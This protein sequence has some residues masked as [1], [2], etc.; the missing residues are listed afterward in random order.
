MDATHD[1]AA[2]A[3]AYLARVEAVLAEDKL[4][5]YEPYGWQREFHNAGIDNPER[6][7]MAASRVGKSLA[8]A[9]EVAIHLTG[10]YPSWW[11][12]KR[13]DGAILVWCGSVSNEA[14]RDIV[15]KQLIGGTGEELGRGWI[16]KRC[17][18]GKPT[19]RQAGVANVVDTVKVRHVSGGLSTLVTKTYEQGWRKWQG[20]APHVVWLDEE[21]GSGVGSASADDYRI[22]EEAQTRILTSGGVVLV[23]FTPLLG[24]T[25]L[26]EHFLDD[27]IQGTYIKSATWDDA[28]H[29]PV[30]EKERLRG[31][32]PV[33]VVE[34]RTLGIPMVGEGRVWQVAQQDIMC[35]PFD[36][37]KFPWYAIICGIDF[38]IAVGHP[39]AAVW[40][41]W[42]R[43]SDVIYFYDCYRA[44]GQTAVYHAHAIRT[45]GKWIP[46]A[47]PHDGMNREKTGGRTLAEAY[48][49][50][51]VNMLG[52]SARYQSRVGGPQP[53]EPIVLDMYE[54][55]RTGRL[56][57]FSHLTQW[58]EEFRSY[59]RKD[60][61]IVA[62][63][64]DLL[65]ASMYAIMMKRYA[66]TRSQAEGKESGSRS[67]QRTESSYEH[68]RRAY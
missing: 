5:D 33:H 39:A 27:K 66:L 14:S 26:V 21:P 7:L 40:A 37:S 54:R 30:D 32:Y 65:K 28:P 49:L 51:E 11:K 23:T 46:V 4:A 16:P 63:K 19:M 8:G 34:A 43:D 9:A 67:P 13:F 55:M 47:W 50:H 20:T 24:E 29:L 36:V 1:R 35:D 53:I 56:K 15:Q 60:G 48:R 18:V 10:L 3:A 62:R 68:E 57:V 59:H 25:Q 42:N 61:R 22:F 12:G 52:M 58:F 17:I 45:R 38:G 6:M 41:A 2:E 31:S 64:D 44:E